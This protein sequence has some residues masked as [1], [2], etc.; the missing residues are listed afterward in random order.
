ML[1]TK[2]MLMSGSGLG[3]RRTCPALFDLN[4]LSSSPSLKRS[5]ELSLLSKG[6]TTDLGRYAYVLSRLHTHSPSFA[7]GL[8][9]SAPG[10]RVLLVR[11]CELRAAGRLMYYL[12]RYGHAA[13]GTAR[14]L[15][16]REV[17]GRIKRGL[18]EY[19]T[20]RVVGGP[21]EGAEY[22]FGVG[23]L[24]YRGDWGTQEADGVFRTIGDVVMS[25][26]DLDD[27]SN[28]LWGLCMVDCGLGG[29][30]LLTVGW[31]R[32]MV[33]SMWTGLPGGGEGG[34]HPSQLKRLRNVMVAARAAGLDLNMSQEVRAALSKLDGARGRTDLT[35]KKVDNFS[36]AVS[37]AMLRQGI[38]KT[39]G[40]WNSPFREGGARDLGGGKD[41]DM[42]VQFAF[43]EENVA[44]VLDGRN[45][46]RR[47]SDEPNGLHK[48]KGRVLES[49][50]WKVKRTSWL[51]WEHV[52]GNYSGK[53]TKEWIV[54]GMRE[55]GVDLKFRVEPK[56]K[57][58]DLY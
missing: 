26:G 29:M 54:G 56:W 52:K 49:Q 30:E 42:A 4:T 17:T 50:G 2:T 40:R 39:W 5:L 43:P 32:E 47:E 23:K 46:F 19:G 14:V 15:G 33:S 41:S 55:M 20:Y 45:F 10:L 9:T 3:N 8:E 34:M 28:F 18:E 37:M 25:E 31:A 58:D 27:F 16:G 36:H 11:H 48:V 57:D 35:N 6:S 44:W 21:K 13:R 1:F 12:G 38:D 24:G 22:V 7:L 51:E 53:E